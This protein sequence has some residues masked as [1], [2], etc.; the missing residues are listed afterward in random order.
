MSPRK[1]QE[2]KSEAATHKVREAALKLFSHQG[3]GATSMR[4]IADACGLSVG[5][6]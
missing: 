6:L 3:Y 5:N 4:Q 2:E 1:R